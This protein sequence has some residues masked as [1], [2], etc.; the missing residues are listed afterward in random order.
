[1]LPRLPGSMR[2]SPAVATR[3]GLLAAA[4]IVAAAVL[5]GCGGHHPSPIAAA[6]NRPGPESIFEPKGPLFADPVG[7]L[8]LMRRLGVDRVKVFIPWNTIAPNPLSRARPRLNAANP[9]AYPASA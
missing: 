6:L 4:V 2:F 3:S 1:M 8:A 5:G 9:G 7:T